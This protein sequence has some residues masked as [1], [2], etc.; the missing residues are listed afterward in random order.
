MAQDDAQLIEVD[1]MPLARWLKLL[2]DPP[3]GALFVDY[4][5]P[6]EGHLQEYVETVGD[7]SE[8]GDP[9]LATQAAD[10]ID[11]FRLR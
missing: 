10:T 7:R 3:Y 8:R 2:F 6:T 9:A 11:V 4:K 5:F 1:D